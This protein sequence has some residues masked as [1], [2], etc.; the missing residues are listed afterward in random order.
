M[1]L[2]VVSLLRATEM[3]FPPPPTS[4]LSIQYQ[5]TW[6]FFLPRLSEFNPGSRDV[7]F[8]VGKVKLG[9]VFSEYFGF[10][11]IYDSIPDVPRLLI[12]Q[13]F[14]LY[15]LETDSMFK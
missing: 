2:V 5:T 9:Q 12:I 1:D 11:A 8:V 6:L 15:N 3:A 7:A 13:S 10:S 4:I 14:T